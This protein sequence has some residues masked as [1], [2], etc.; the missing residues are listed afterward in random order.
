[1]PFPVPGDGVASLED[2]AAHLTQDYPRSAPRAVAIYEAPDGP[3]RI[4]SIYACLDA[5][6]DYGFPGASLYPAAFLKERLSDSSRA[7]C[8]AIEDTVGEISPSGN[9]GTL[10]MGEGWAA[11][12]EYAKGPGRTSNIELALRVDKEEFPC[13]APV[14]PARIDLFFF[15]EIPRITE[16]RQVKVTASSDYHS[17]SLSGVRYPHASLFTGVPRSFGRKRCRYFGRILAG[18]GF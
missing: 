3:D 10:L 15:T 14:E 7:H 5:A 6:R 18:L 9:I 12:V 16:D 4:G 2:V 11:I 8:Y 1:M 13:G 17:E